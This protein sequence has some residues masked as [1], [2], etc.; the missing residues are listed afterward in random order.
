MESFAPKRRDAR[1][2]FRGPSTTSGGPVVNAT[3]E[4]RDCFSNNQR[5]VGGIGNSTPYHAMILGGPSVLLARAAIL[6]VLE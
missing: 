1:L 2:E 5:K 4:V 3:A 6:I